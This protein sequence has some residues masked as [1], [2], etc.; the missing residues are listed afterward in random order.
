MAVRYT[1]DRAYRVSVLPLGIFLMFG[2]VV[3]VLSAVF[4]PMTPVWIMPPFDDPWLKRV[5]FGGLGFLW[6]PIGLGLCFRSRITWFGLFTY[7][8]LGIIWQVTAGFLDPRLAS[9]VV[10]SPLVNI[11]IAVGIYFVTK[12]VFVRNGRQDAAFHGR[13]T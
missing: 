13:N 9:F 6:V 4:M 5:V 8:L 12:P 3:F 10:L 11:P 2:G 7:M 1:A